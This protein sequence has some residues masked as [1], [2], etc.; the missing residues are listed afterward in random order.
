MFNPQNVRENFSIPEDYHP[1]SCWAL[2][3]L[4]DPQS[5]PENYRKLEVQP[6][7]RKPI[8]SFAFT[9]WEQAAGF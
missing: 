2:G 3:Y 8:A 5:L 9:E 1:I 6:R 4:G 7:R